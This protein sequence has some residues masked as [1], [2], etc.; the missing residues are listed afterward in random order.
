RAVV[1]LAED[2]QTPQLGVERGIRRTRESHDVGAASQPGW[3]DLL[4]LGRPFAS[5][6]RERALQVRSAVDRAGERYPAGPPAGLVNEERATE[7]RGIAI[8]AEAHRYGAR[9]RG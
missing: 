4:D 8:D 5:R 6:V 2:S 9:T 1:G 7:I 3:V